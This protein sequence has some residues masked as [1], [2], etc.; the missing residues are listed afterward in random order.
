MAEE[1]KNTGN[2]QLINSFVKGMVKDFTDVYVPEGVWTNAIN[3]VNNAHS[4]E[5][6]AIGNEQSNLY[7]ATFPYTVIGIINTKQ[8]WLYLVQTTLILK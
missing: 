8:S 2:P 3:A 1:S 6:G 4:G 5:Q 7:C